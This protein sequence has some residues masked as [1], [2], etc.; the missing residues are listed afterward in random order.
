MCGV[1]RVT[2]NAFADGRNDNI[3]RDNFARVAVFA[4][5]ATNVF[6][7]CHYRGPYRSRGTLRDRFELERPLSLRCKL[8]VDSLEQCRDLAFVHMTSQLRVNSA[9]MNGGCPHATHAMSLIE[10]NGKENIRRLGASVRDERIVGHTLETGVVEIH[11]RE[12]VP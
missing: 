2:S 12:T 9:R 3:V 10:S 6:G 11:V 4:V 1:E 7:C 5:S 8:T